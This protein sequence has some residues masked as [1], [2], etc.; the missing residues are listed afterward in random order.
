MT[1]RER[2]QTTF[3]ASRLFRSLPPE[4]MDSLNPRQGQVREG[5]LLFAEGD[6][7]ATAYVIESGILGLFNGALEPS[8]AWFRKAVRGDLVGEYGLLS[9]EPRSASAIALTDLSYFC[10]EPADLRQLLAQSPELQRRLITS[11]AD[12]ASIGRDPRRSALTT[13]AIHNASPESPLTRQV[14][15]VLSEHLLSQAAGQI[16]FSDAATLHPA[17]SESD[18]H[19]QL[20]EA[21]GAGRTRLFLTEAPQV[22]SRRNQKLIDRLLILTDGTA[23]QVTLGDPIPADCILVRLWPPEQVRPVTKPWSGSLQPAFTLNIRACLG[24]HRDRLAR[25]VLRRQTVLVLGGGGARGFAH[26]GAIAALQER[27]PDDIDMVMG[28]SIGALVASLAAFDLPAEEI[29]GHL[30]RV[31]IDARPYSLILSRESL[32]SLANSQRE[33]EAFFADSRIEDSWLALQCFSTNLSTNRLEAWTSGDIPAAVVSSMAVPGIFPPVEDFQGH[34]HVDGGI[35]NNLPVAPARQL[36]DGRIIAISL[37][38]EPESSPVAGP[39]G[40]P[41]RPSLARTLVDAMMCASHAVSQ[42]QE[43]LAD[44]LLKPEIGHIPFLDWKSYSQSF[45]AGYNHTRQRLP[46]RREAD[47]EPKDGEVAL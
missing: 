40:P 39:E 4:C 5:D 34:L 15:A 7:A 37:D 29:L 46:S 13:I 24:S 11:L 36:T 22:L 3:A 45:E 25:T 43:R 28:V 6:P 42:S 19:Q 12:A 20:T 26:V 2:L 30:K 41:R 35:L 17:R 44:L 16:A 47:R 1:R 18:L 23:E 27:G 33:L 9:D 31:I 8:T 14:L 10:L 21:T 38:G 32:F